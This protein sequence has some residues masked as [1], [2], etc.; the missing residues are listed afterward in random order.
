MIFC[1]IRL[2]EVCEFAPNNLF[3]IFVS[4]LSRGYLEVGVWYHIVQKGVCRGVVLPY[5]NLFLGG[6]KNGMK[7]NPL[8]LRNKYQ[9]GFYCDAI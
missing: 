9:N 8:V 3:F 5:N 1:I 2:T 7:S 6:E 4:P